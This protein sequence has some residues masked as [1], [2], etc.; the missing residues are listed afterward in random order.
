MTQCAAVLMC[1]FCSRFSEKTPNYAI[2][3]QKSI[4]GGGGVYCENK[5]LVIH[6]GLFA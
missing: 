3:F 4:I 5:G 6:L 2:T 1:V